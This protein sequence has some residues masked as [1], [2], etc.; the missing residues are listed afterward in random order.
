MLHTAG[1]TVTPP[2]RLTV[3]P[4]G[5]ADSRHRSGS[6]SGLSGIR[7]TPLWLRDSLGP[8]STSPT[9]AVPRPM[10][11]AARVPADFRNYRRLLG[12]VH[13]RF[14]V[15][16]RSHCGSS[17]AARINQYRRRP[18]QPSGVV[19]FLPRE[20]PN[21]RHSARSAAPLRRIR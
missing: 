21:R 2:A 11:A 20:Q 12:L 18:N 17:S 19:G 13:F 16:R 1:G 6:S 7:N 10:A 4:G 14:N 15:L 8:H 3:D 9:R 5:G